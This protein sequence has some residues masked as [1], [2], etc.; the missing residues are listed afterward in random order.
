M[1]IFYTIILIFTINSCISQNNEVIITYKAFSRGSS[2][3]IETDLD[4]ISYHN[5]NEYKKLEINYPHQKEIKKI[6]SQINIIELG[7]LK[8]PSTKSYSDAALQASIKIVTNKKT[9]VSQTFDH[10]NPPEELKAIIEKLFKI[11]Q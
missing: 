4:S 6:L 10:G 3:K 8:P 5:N 2:I 7:T 1:K 9:F 11:V